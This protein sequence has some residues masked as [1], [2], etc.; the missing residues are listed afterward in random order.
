MASSS[1]SSSSPSSSPSSSSAPVDSRA[2]PAAAVTEQQPDLSRLS[3]G[4]F[5]LLTK[6]VQTYVGQLR[7]LGLL[8]NRRHDLKRDI[9][10][11]EK[12]L[13]GM[14]RSS[15][16]R[17]DQATRTGDLTTIR[18]EDIYCAYFCDLIHSNRARVDNFKDD[19]IFARHARDLEVIRSAHRRLYMFWF[20]KH[21][22]VDAFMKTMHYKMNEK[23]F[24]SA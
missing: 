9:S 14:V 15:C 23:G 21:G 1:S 12:E 17:R 19:E 22:N 10:E 13:L 8:M 11:A 4:D 24:V 5:Y 3:P 18:R 20:F 2:L 7:L 6:L 16:R